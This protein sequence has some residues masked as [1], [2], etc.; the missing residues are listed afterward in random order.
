MAV[1]ALH[2]GL[3]NF[4]RAHQCVYFQRAG[5]SVASCNLRSRGAVDS[6]LPRGGRFTLLTL[7]G[8]KADAQEITSLAE[9]VYY[10]DDPQAWL[11]RFAEPAIRLVTITVTEKGYPRNPQGGLALDDAG[12]RRDLQRALPPGSMIGVLAEGLSRRRSLGLG[13]LPVVSCDNLPGN[14]GI[15]KRL[16]TDYARQFDE[17]LAL[18]IEAEC[19]FP[20]TMVDCIVPAIRQEDR[21][22]A[23][24]LIGY[25]DQGLVVAEPFRLWVMENQWIGERPLFD[26][27]DFLWVEDAAPFDAMKLRLLNA[28]HTALACLGQV[29]GYDFIWQAATDP[30]FAT[31]AA[32][33]Q[34]ELLT[35]VPPTP[36]YDQARYISAI[37]TRFS[38]RAL[39]H[40]TSQVASD[41]S[42]KLPI[43]LL[44]PAQERLAAGWPSPLI[45]VAVAGW[46][47]QVIGTT[48]Q[49]QSYAISDPMA[50]QLANVVSAAGHNPARLCASLMAQERV[51][52][53]ALREDGVFVDC[54]CAALK[55]MQKSGVRQALV[56]L[57]M[58]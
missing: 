50:E 22:R 46:M 18:W 55:T 58:K 19:R 7:D 20:S 28:V 25:D 5:L 56:E 54:V 15:L 40:R 4:H 27:P 6:L 42:Q 52:P 11:D 10:P 16:V 43:R 14:G 41:S 30:V 38:N 57:G 8:E 39:P 35:T 45:A 26:G 37:L 47:R 31:Y 2:I 49:G 48:E 53:E 21:V 17:G 33:L 51:F 34:Q 32:R 36:G 23:Q 44:A 3:G 24:A 13:G 9:P 12:I 1:D 29:A